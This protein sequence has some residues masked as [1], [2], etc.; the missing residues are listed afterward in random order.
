MIKVAVCSGVRIEPHRGGDDGECEAA[1]AGNQR[2][3]K[4][5]TEEKEREEVE[6]EIRIEVRMH[7]ARSQS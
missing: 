5:A 2:R 7:E 3:G 4:R 1:K 6:A